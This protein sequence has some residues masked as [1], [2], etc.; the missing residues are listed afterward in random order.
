MTAGS[1]ASGSL[2]TRTLVLLSLAVVLVT[3]AALA[4]A[5]SSEDRSVPPPP[6]IAEKLVILQAERAELQVR[7]DS[8][9]RIEMLSSFRAASLLFDALASRYE[10][11]RE[12][13]FDRLPATRRE[14][15]AR[16]EA[17]NAALR[18][19]IDRPGTP[20]GPLP[21]HRR[22]A[23]FQRT[24]RGWRP[25]IPR[26]SFFPTRRCSWRPGAPRRVTRR[27]P[28]LRPATSP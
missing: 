18:A 16:L 3:S 4:Y 20:G 8:L 15:F 23:A 13:P 11:E 12:Q 28:P 22:R 9:A 6:T 2:W 24:W 19:A 21:C 26:R 5:Q 25:S 10:A 1:P 17:V 27:L 14:M 7:A